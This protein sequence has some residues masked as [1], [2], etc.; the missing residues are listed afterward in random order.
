MPNGRQIGSPGTLLISENVGQTGNRC[1]LKPSRLE[2][3]EMGDRCRT[4]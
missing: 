3:D 4:G 2:F 1:P